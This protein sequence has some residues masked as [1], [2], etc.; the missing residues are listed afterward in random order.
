[1]QVE[2]VVPPQPI[3]A[4]E[5]PPPPP[6]RNFADLIVGVVIDTARNV[7]QRGPTIDALLKQAVNGQMSN[8]Q[9]LALQMTIN[10]YSLEVD[11]LS[12]L[13]QQAV[14]GLKDV[15]RTQV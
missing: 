5:P 6:E 15:L 10:R 7:E 13:V 1:M 9:L 12:K 3:T 8:G 2:A 4:P 11:L 14:Q